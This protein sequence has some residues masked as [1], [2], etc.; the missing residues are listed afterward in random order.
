M[1]AG[2]L[3]T[4]AVPPCVL[5]DADCLTPAQHIRLMAVASVITGIVRLLAD[6]PGTAILH[7]LVVGMCVTFDHAARCG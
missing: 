3:S 6:G 2:T 5:P 4:K 1:D 7:G